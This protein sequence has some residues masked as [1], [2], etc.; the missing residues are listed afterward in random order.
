MA[1]GIKKLRT[2]RQRMTDVE[3][4]YLGKKQDY[5]KVV[6]QMELEKE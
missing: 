4:E 3:E 6:N 1:P 5:D 2:L